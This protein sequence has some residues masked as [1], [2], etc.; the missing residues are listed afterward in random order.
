MAIV[1]ILG[2]WVGISALGCIVLLAAAA[3]QLPQP[4]LIPVRQSASARV[5]GKAGLPAEPAQAV[6]SLC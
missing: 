3:R 5:T 4:E 2:A 1:V 6:P